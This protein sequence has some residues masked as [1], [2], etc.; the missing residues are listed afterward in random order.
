LPLE[1]GA[2]EE[3]PVVHNETQTASASLSGS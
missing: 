3:V 1:E 2:V